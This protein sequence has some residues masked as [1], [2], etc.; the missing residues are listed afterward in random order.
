[1]TG[2]RSSEA[3][4][5]RAIEQQRSTFLIG[6]EVG[7]VPDEG[8]RNFVRELAGAL[9][10]GGPVHTYTAGSE[11]APDLRHL[12]DPLRLL[13]GPALFRDLRRY[14]P[15]TIVY[16]YMATLPALLRARLLKLLAPDATVVIIA[17]QP[18]PLRGPARVLARLLWPDLLLVTSESERRE[19]L[20]LGANAGCIF[21]GVDLA[22]FRPPLPGEK[23][24]LRR[25]W[26]LPLD[27]Q[28]V[29]HVGSL[30]YGRN[31]Q[32]LVPLVAKPGTTVAVLVSRHQEPDSRRLKNELQ[33]RG[34]KV[35]EGYQAQ[36]E[37]L[38]RLAD[39]YVFP[40]VSP[41]S[42]VAFPLSVLEAMASDLPVA[43]TRFGA[44]SEHFG[45]EMGVRFADTPR[46]LTAAVEAL[47]ELRPSTRYLAERYSWEATA[48]RLLTQLDQIRSGFRRNRP[49]LKH[50]FSIVL[51]LMRRRRSRYEE[52]LRSLFWGSRL[53]FEPQRSPTERV[54]PVE[55]G[56]KSG[57]NAHLDSPPV[58]NIGLLAADRAA[59]E[60]TGL[61]QAARFYGLRP[62]AA[63]FGDGSSL[64]AQAVRERWPL[65]GVSLEALTTLPGDWPHFFGQFLDGGGT[66][67]LA[68]V[69]PCSAQALSAISRELETSLP[70][71]RELPGAVNPVLF[72]GGSSLAQEFSGVRIE[73]CQSRI[74]LAGNEE[75]DVVAWLLGEHERLPAVVERRVRA[76]RIILCAGTQQVPSTLAGAYV[77]RHA[78]AVLPSLMI[79]RQVYGQAAWHAPA[80]LANF[81][82][83]DPVLRNGLLGMDYRR[84]LA[85]AVAHDFHLTIATVPRDLNLAAAEVVQLFQDNPLHLSACYHGNDHDGYEFYFPNARQLR[86]RGR[87]LPGQRRALEE[88]VKR[89]ERF[90]LGT[91]Y[92]LDRVMVF[93]HG[94]GPVEILPSLAELGFLATCNCFDRYPLGGSPPDDLDVAMRPADLAWAG[95][96][97]IWR[98]GLSDA[99]FV[100][101]LFVGRPTITFAHRTEL[102]RDLNPFAER[103]RTINQLAHG[104]ARWRSLE[105]IA[106]HCYLQRR[107]PQKG[108]Q[109]RMLSTEIC[110]H[111]PD[112][113]TRIYRVH[114]P[115]RPAGTYLAAEGTETR[116]ADELLVP[117]AAASTAIVRL[118][119]P[120]AAPL[121][122]IRPSP[123]CSIFTTSK[124]A[125]HKP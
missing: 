86:W 64:L 95:F 85:Q 42:A 63:S 17:L 74:F 49:G 41:D 1:M 92:A 116:D 102:G 80:T 71:C 47:L 44:L 66:L 57:D 88:A 59:A 72:S 5:E 55:V 123:S 39:C 106:R 91:G 22:R 37:E 119:R 70:A 103:A 96:P 104:R 77:P 30:V 29:L 101:D 69:K 111:N 18:C 36:V 24:A 45:G 26:G 13:V 98:R 67:F 121:Q 14:R 58:D 9:S 16:V 23:A 7:G 79:I 33:E 31:L 21:S 117:V 8:Y 81:T 107:D 11:P 27:T 48:A 25:K 110:L 78:M 12:P 10:R 118:T 28:V 15:K 53:G 76:G 54:R 84:A 6:K 105:E 108:W 46:E 83:D 115:R 35:L 73:G 82:I 112:T 40:V 93:P 89:G 43:T 60:S 113:A 100:F 94:L 2:V 61:V 87:P 56:A 38:Y 51:A 97:L 68:D 65:L 3:S 90:A 99:T 109:V 52:R 4:S 20:R 114:R 32:A 19:A 50:R 124:G 34:I 75:G 125:G 120:P 122:R 62:A